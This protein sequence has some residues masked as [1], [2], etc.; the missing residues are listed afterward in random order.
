MKVEI[1][2]KKTLGDTQAGFRKGRCTIDNVYIMQQVI[3]K[4]LKI[5]EGK[6]YVHIVNLKAAFDESGRI[7]GN[8]GKEGLI[9]EGLIEG[10]KEVY[11]E[12]KNVIRVGEEETDEFWTMGGV[13]QGI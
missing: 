8:D 13:R 4:E 2:E 7:V 9:K 10:I 6:I 11:Q 5:R 12:I 1:E 3:E